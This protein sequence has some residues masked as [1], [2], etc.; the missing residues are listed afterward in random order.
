MNPTSQ[1]FWADVSLKE[2]SLLAE[3]SAKPHFLSQELQ[4]LD[5]L[6]VSSV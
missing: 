4:R 6:P 1:L 5:T 3:A 2:L